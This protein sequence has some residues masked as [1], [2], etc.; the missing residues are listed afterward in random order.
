MIDPPP[1]PKMLDIELVGTD[2]APV[3]FANY[4][5]AHHSDHE[6]FL[7]FAQI[8]PA[9]TRNIDEVTTIQARTQVHIAMNPKTFYELRRTVE[10]VIQQ[11][12]SY[13]GRDAI[14]LDDE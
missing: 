11:W 8:V 12:E 13:G 7:T 4:G 6:F 1:P 9:F 10:A 2:E 5:T 3:V 14:V